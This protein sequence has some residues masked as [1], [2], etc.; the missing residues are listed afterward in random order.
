MLEKQ[1]DFEQDLDG[2]NND[3]NVVQTN[4]DILNS[5][6][7]YNIDLENLEKTNPLWKNAPNSE[8]KRSETW[9]SLDVN[10]SDVVNVIISTSERPAFLIRDDKLFYINRAALKLIEIESDRDVI[11]KNFFN[12]VASEDWKMLAENIGEML[13]SAKHQLIHLKSA[14]GKIIPLIFQAIYLSEIEHFSFLLIGEHVKKEHKIEFNNLYDD[15]T[16]LPN[17]FLFEDRVQVAIASEGAMEN[18]KYQKFI[19]VVVININ[20]MEAF[21]KMHIEE[22]II[23]KMANN[24][25][26]NL[27]KNATVARGIKYNFWIMLPELKNKLEINHEIRRI[28]EILNEGINDNFTRHEILYSLGISSFPQPAHSAKKIIE[29]AIAAV[30]K[31]KENVKNLVVFFGNEM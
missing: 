18:A 24:L 15:L 14:D 11:G 6:K 29:Q 3:Y 31:A 8:K 30:K 9:R 7:K 19:A 5:A 20:N 12:L 26:L 23:K 2:D 27:P 4:L 25:V 21:R 13:T 22:L 28:C 1:I 10:L 16:G 17:F